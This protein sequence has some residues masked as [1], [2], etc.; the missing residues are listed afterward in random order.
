MS[1]QLELRVTPGTPVYRGHDH[2]WQVMRDL[3]KG[4][5][6]FT[7]AEV[8]G[9]SNDPRDKS[10]GDFIH[11]LIK[12]EIVEVSRTFQDATARGGSVKHNV[13]RL[14]SR[15]TKT[16]IINRDGSVGTQGAKNANMWTAMRCLSQFTKHDLAIAAA[17]DDLPISVHSAA[18][19]IHHLLK[20]GYLLIMRPSR[21]RNPAVW[22]LK[23][24]MNTGPEAP[25]I[26]KTKVVYD[27]N[28]GQVMGAPVAEECAA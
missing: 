1:I 28:K 5:A 18:T 2:Y 8:A 6:E 26:L 4:N 21:S 14:L 22:R 3:G 17:T 11:R 27:V 16:P 9:R 19:Y 20:A 12:A 25:R 24:S 15:P 23:P 10:I 7:L 13:Y